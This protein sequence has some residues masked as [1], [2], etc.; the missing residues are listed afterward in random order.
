ML[1][2]CS[3]KFTVAEDNEQQLINNSMG[4]SLLSS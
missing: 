2:Y 4:Q 3:H 1:T